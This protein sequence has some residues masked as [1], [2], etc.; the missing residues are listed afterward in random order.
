V[1]ISELNISRHREHHNVSII[2]QNV[3]LRMAVEYQLMGLAPESKIC[4]PSLNDLGMTSAM[5]H[6]ALISQCIM[7]FRA[8]KAETV[9]R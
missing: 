3:L 6:T 7:C 5:S 8:G 2:P 4:M 9:L 1:N